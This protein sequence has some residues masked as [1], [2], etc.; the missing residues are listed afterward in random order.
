M[1]EIAVPRGLD[2]VIARKTCVFLPPA[3]RARGGVAETRAVLTH[4]A[5]AARTVPRRARR[6]GGGCGAPA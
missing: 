4:G 1:L 5:R 2:V 3:R 6:S